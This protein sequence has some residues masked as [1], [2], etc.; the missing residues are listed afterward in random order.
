[1]KKV[2]ADKSLNIS[3]DDFTKP[4]IPGVDLNFDCDRYEK[5]EAIEYIDEF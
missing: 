3:K 1:M 5:V 4:N 2:Y